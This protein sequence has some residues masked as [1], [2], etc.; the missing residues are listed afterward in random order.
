MSSSGSALL[1]AGAAT[2]GAVAL[3]LYATRRESAGAEAPAEEPRL[4]LIDPT[5]RQ[6]APAEPARGGVTDTDETRAK[7]EPAG[8]LGKFS[9]LW[10][11]VVRSPL[12]V[13]LG[14]K[15]RVTYRDGQQ[16]RAVLLGFLEHSRTAVWHLEAADVTVRLPWDQEPANAPV[17]DPSYDKAARGRA[18]GVQA[19]QWYAELEG[20]GGP[21]GLQEGTLAREVQSWQ[22]EARRWQARDG[23]VITEQR[24]AVVDPLDAAK[25]LVGGLRG[26]VSPT[27]LKQLGAIAPGDPAYPYVQIPNR[28][29]GLAG[30]IK[31]LF[32]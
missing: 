17:R 5:Q 14:S 21:R 20:W 30:R 4:L 2:L 31:D 27:N 10:N 15:R 26:L 28:V 18:G 24:A 6:Q 9:A 23:G 3:A 1:T 13:Q 32:R 19:A 11:R 12:P 29:R 25:D 16:D 7:G 22:H 8:P